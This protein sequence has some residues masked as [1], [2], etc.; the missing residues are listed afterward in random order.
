MNIKTKEL[1]LIALLAS[2]ALGLAWR[3]DHDY[4]A[5]LFCDG[6]SDCRRRGSSSFIVSSPRRDV[7]TI[8]LQCNMNA[9]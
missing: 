7:S 9:A 8:K 6:G 1:A 2:L 3:F 5:I 4:F